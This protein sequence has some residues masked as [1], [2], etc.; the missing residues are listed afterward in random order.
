MFRSYRATISMC[1][2]CSER[3]QNIISVQRRGGLF[4]FLTVIPPP[5]LSRHGRRRTDSSP[6]RRARTLARFPDLGL[7]LRILMPLQL[8][9]AMS[10]V[11]PLPPPLL[12]F[13]HFPVLLLG[14]LD[15]L[16]L[17][18]RRFPRGFPRVCLPLPC[19]I[20]HLGVI[21]ESRVPYTIMATFR[22]PLR[23]SIPERASVARVVKCVKRLSCV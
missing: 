3:V 5:F 16:L 17:R 8:M 7:R 22:S 6:R 14:T 12:P 21:R 2:S 9:H 1:R 18:H 20:N 4:C 15:L 11:R 23:I 13:L 19:I 10:N